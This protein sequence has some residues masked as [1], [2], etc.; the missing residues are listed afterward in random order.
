MSKKT[1]KTFASIALAM[2]ILGV[3]VLIIWWSIIQW[4]ECRDLGHTI[5]YC[6]AH[7]S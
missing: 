5:L 2:F 6:I 3:P 4:N 1:L 7:I